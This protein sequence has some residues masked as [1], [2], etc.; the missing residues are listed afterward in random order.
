MQKHFNQLGCFEQKTLRQ[1][2][3]KQP[4]NNVRDH[5]EGY[6]IDK[7]SKTQS[8]NVITL[9]PN[10]FDDINRMIA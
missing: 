4:K 5:G 2:Y 7:N 6:F 9:E 8:V 3:V 10:I 1:K